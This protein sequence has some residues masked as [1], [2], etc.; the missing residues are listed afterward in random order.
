MI[1]K[2]SLEMILGIMIKNVLP[3]VEQSLNLRVVLGDKFDDQKPAYLA[4]KS[5]DMTEGQIVR[6]R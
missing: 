6:D 5:G 2:G 3:G 1:S 4:Q